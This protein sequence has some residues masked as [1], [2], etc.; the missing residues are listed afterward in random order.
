MATWRLSGQGG[1]QVKGFQAVLRKD[2]PAA[3]L[4][5]FRVKPVG[6]VA[7]QIS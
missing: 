1:A 4:L 2:I 7:S 6:N 5:L 3:L